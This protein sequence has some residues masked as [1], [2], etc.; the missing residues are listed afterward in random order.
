MEASREVHSVCVGIW[1]K[2]GSRYETPAKNGISHILEHMF[3]KG[4]QSRT[5]QD[6]AIEIDSVGG[7]INALTSTEYTLFYVKVLEEYM[8]QALG[9]LTDIFLQSNFPEPDIEKDKNIVYEEI[10]MV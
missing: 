3:F 8:E 7:E 6:I 5:A 1:V 10:N 9:L 4:T 2:V